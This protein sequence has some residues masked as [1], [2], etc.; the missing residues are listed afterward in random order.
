MSIDFDS[1][2]DR[3]NTNSLKYDFAVERGKPADILPLWVADMDFKA[4]EPVLNALHE[5]VTHG[6]FGYSE[7]KTEYF[8]ALHQ[9][10][11][12]HFGWDVREEWLVKT[13]GVVFALALAVKAFTLEGDA[14]LIQQPVYYPF[15][16]T[17]R[18]NNRRLVINELV[19]CDGK[20]QIDYEDFEKKII[21]E[22]VRLFILCNPQNPVGRVW[23]PEELERMGD[24]CIKHQVLIVS[25]E[26]HCDFTYP[27]F[28][29]T[30]LA[31]MNDIFAEHTITC[32]SPSKTF[33]LAGL[34]VSNIFIKNETL[35]AR[36][37]K[38]LD[39]SGYSQ[40]N[41]LGLIACQAAY[42][43]GE[44]WLSE[45]KAY[46]YENLNYVREYLKENLPQIQLIEPEGTYLIWL[47]FSSLGLSS[48][49]MKALIVNKANLWLDAGQMFGRSGA[50]YER[51]NIACP[52]AILQK[53]L[54]QL[55]NAILSLTDK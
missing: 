2:I 44:V 33:N 37:I 17:I 14:I 5:A 15:E 41:S 13:P 18:L 7:V 23:T 21:T 48:A 30:V 42:R 46:L 8:D 9:W 43:Y 55:R 39:R 35:R 4:P 40:L 19:N 25:D 52:R 22:Q 50:G 36:F 24:I 31:G 3:R 53:A 12:G 32:T 26:I 51:I 16:E 28:V 38:E 29:H 54:E 1:I 27:G 10:F 49:E 47:D 34:Q 45:L 6:I 11:Y 20:Y